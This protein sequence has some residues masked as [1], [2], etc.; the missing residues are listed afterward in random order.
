MVA[1][2][3]REA[4]LQPAKCV[5]EPKIRR[6]ISRR[7]ANAPAISPPPTRFEHPAEADPD[8]AGVQIRRPRSRLN[9]SS[10]RVR[11]VVRRDIAAPGAVM[12]GIV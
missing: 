8:G 9:L 6:R 7:R 11:G 3:G 1:E 4:F 5:S 2:L 12:G 10:H